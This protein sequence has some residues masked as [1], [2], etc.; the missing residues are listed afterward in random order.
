MLVAWFH[1]GFHAVDADLG[2]HGLGG[3]SVVAGE[4]DDFE[5]ELVEGGDGLAGGGFDGVGDGKNTGRLAI[6]GDEDGRLAELL[7]GL[8]LSGE[9]IAALHGV[10]AQEGELADEDGATVD[11]GADSAAGG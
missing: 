1:A 5:P 2:G 9:L 8:G 10:F 11:F 3:F 7:E 6:H 4:H